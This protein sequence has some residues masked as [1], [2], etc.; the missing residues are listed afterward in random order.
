MRIR[1]FCFACVVIL[2][3]GAAGLSLGRNTRKTVGGSAIVIP[4]NINSLKLGKDKA[5][6][7]EADEFEVKETIYAV[8]EISGVE[9]PVVVKGRLLVDDVPGQQRGPIPG[10]EA[11]LNMA[12]EG[13]ADFNFSAPTNGWPK[14]KYIV[15]VVVIGGDGQVI[16]KKEAEFSVE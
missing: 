15:Q 9:G 4:G 11:T 6:S 8:A 7:E 13:R 1:M 10:L 2:M 16:D 12:S 14:G 3:L 5:V